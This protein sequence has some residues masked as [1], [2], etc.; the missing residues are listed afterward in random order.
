MAVLRQRWCNSLAA[1]KKQ[2]HP[3]HRCSEIMKVNKFKFVSWSSE[4]IERSIFEEAPTKDGLMAAI[5][6]NHPW[7]FWKGT[8]IRIQEK[9]E[10]MVQ[11]NDA[12]KWRHRLATTVKF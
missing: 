8:K 5:T 6:R 1:I 9:M 12:L 2:I 11:I 4:R 7:K 3:S 10:V